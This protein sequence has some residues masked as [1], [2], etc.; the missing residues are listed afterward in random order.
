MQE[1][2]EKLKV[3]QI[4]KQLELKEAA[5]RRK[6]QALKQQLQGSRNVVQSPPAPTS[7]AGLQ[8]NTMYHSSHVDRLILEPSH[9]SPN[10][11][12][13]HAQLHSQQGVTRPSQSQQLSSTVWR[14]KAAVKPPATAPGTVQQGQLNKHSLVEVARSDIGHTGSV[15]EN[16]HIC[17]QH[18]NKTMQAAHV[19][20]SFIPESQASPSSR[21]NVTGPQQSVVGSLLKMRGK[22]ADLP[23][24]TNTDCKST[25][26]S[27]QLLQVSTTA[28]HR[29]ERT[30]PNLEAP[31]KSSGQHA[32]TLNKC[33][34]QPHHYR[35]TNSVE[36]TNK[37]YV[38][39]QSNFGTSLRRSQTTE[40]RT[41]EPF[42]KDDSPK[43][44]LTLPEEVKETEYMTAVQRQKVRVSR[45]RRCI[46]AATVIQRAWREY[47]QRK[48]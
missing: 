15:N 45:I 40:E 47:K 34:E 7:S 33:A 4:E 3:S 5:T 20:L 18:M 32:T 1:Q 44:R 43:P 48:C 26:N 41:L 19:Q 28:S 12:N 30:T 24:S 9:M 36:Q 21:A 29:H 38:N 25:S 39:Q 35:K 6:I 14:E 27:R 37:E 10:S 31:S 8:P 11:N 2:I 16:R 23:P 42:Q 22:D 17:D 13:G 46:I